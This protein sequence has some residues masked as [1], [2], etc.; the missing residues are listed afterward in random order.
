MNK[1]N[2]A[3]CITRKL[4]E[5]RRAARELVVLKIDYFR[6][7]LAP[8]DRTGACRQVPRWRRLTFETRGRKIVVEATKHSR[9][10]VRLYRVQTVMRLRWVRF[11]KIPAVAAA[12]PLHAVFP[13]VSPGRRG[14]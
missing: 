11:R 14:V 1:R 8:E 2:D 4:L 5:L 9:G 10:A 7:C 12:G 6:R 3:R 13:A